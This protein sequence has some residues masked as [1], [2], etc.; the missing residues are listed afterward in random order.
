M[1]R[2]NLKK[3]WKIPVAF[4]A[5][6]FFVSCGNDIEEIKALT[7][8]KELAVQTVE[9]GTFHYTSRGK[10]SN[11][12]VAGILDR[13]EGEDPRIE[14]S[15][16]FTLFIYDSLEQVEATLT[17]RRGTFYDT[18]G[19]LI[20]REDVILENSEG[21]KLNTEELI[22][23]QDSDKVYTDK[24]FI[25]TKDQD[26]IQGIGLISD[27][28]FKKR[29]MNKLTGKIYVDDPAPKDSLDGN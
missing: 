2:G 6:I 5:G 18:E 10:L 16:G 17:A 22:W 11:K 1:V 21:N 3:Y 28:K 26:T 12:L 4:A 20:A 27:S 29:Q 8:N 25:L 15:E 13:Y 9:N 24:P 19:R 14:V 23:V 7:E